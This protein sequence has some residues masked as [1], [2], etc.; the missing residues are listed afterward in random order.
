[1]QGIRVREVAILAEEV[2]QSE[3]IRSNY[4][5]NPQISGLIVLFCYMSTVGYM[6]I[7]LGPRLT[8][9]LCS[10]LSLVIIAG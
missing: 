6:L 9:S 2:Y 7:T 4:S 10:E 8:K 3:R 5:N 1:M